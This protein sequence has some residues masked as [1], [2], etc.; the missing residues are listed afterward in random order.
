MPRI[1]IA[2]PRSFVFYIF[3]YLIC[4]S[5]GENGGIKASRSVAEGTQQ[6]TVSVGIVTLDDWISG[7][8]PC[9]G[10]ASMKVAFVEDGA[11]KGVDFLAGL[12]SSWNGAI[13]PMDMPEN[14][15]LPTHTHAAKP[16]GCGKEGGASRMAWL[17]WY[18]NLGQ[19]F[20]LVNRVSGKKF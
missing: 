18:R 9:M 12:T 3:P 2:I 8:A 4:S 15:V 13:G 17:H 16:L 6:I 1:N 14:P 11:A 19:L 5:I 20:Y 10:L 7:D